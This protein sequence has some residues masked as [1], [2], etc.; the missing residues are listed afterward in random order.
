M[1]HFLLTSIFIFIKKYSPDY[2]D[3]AVMDE[4]QMRS[5]LQTLLI[6]PTQPR[7]L[8]YGRPYPCSANIAPVC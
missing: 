3:N 6:R 5:A 4:K 7:S 8:L 1:V 2:T